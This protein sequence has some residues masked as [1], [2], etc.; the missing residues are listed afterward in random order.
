M[1]AVYGIEERGR[2]KS[3]EIR[4]G[5]RKNETGR[6]MAELK[7][8]LTEVVKDISSKSPLA[9]AIND[10]LGHWDELNVFLTDG[11]V[12]DDT[13]TVERSMRP[14]ALRRKN[15]WFSGSERDARSWP[16]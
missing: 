9:E 1:G 4:L 14:I 2:G 16:M 3:A 6:L 7:M 5:A 15:S 13:N 10:T 11:R 8:R 12:E